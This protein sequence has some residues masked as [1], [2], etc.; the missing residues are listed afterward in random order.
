MASILASNLPSV[1]N[2]NEQESQHN[3]PD[4]TAEVV[5]GC[6]CEQTGAPGMAAQAVEIADVIVPAHGQQ[7]QRQRGRAG[8][9]GLTW[10]LISH[11]EGSALN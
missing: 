11:N 8:Q 9:S 6:D 4:V 7:L 1:C 3:V 10:P 5:E 2:E